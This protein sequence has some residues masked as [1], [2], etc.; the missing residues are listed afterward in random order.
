MS[1]LIQLPRDAVWLSETLKQLSNCLKEQWL[2]CSDE[3]ACIAR[4]E[5]L[6]QLIDYRG[7]SHCFERNAGLDMARYGVG[8][9]LFTLLFPPD[10]IDTSS[11]KNIDAGLM[12]GY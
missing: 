7:W 6:L 8:I 9:Q 10:G 5:W 3:S 4:S 2:K 11:E 12:S 1:F